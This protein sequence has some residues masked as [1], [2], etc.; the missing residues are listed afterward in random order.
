MS[1]LKKYSQHV[2]NLWRQAGFSPRADWTIALGVF[3]LLL[4]FIAVSSTLVFMQLSTES[5][6]ESVSEE[7]QMKTIDRDKL[8][9]T[10][11]YFEERAVSASPDDSV[12]VDP[13]R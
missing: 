5:I 4:I 12:L 8:R 1:T 9:E 2:R 3:A 6:D 13:S 7:I 10:A 11:R